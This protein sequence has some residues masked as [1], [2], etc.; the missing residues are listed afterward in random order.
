[1]PFHLNK[2]MCSGTLTRDPEIKH[3]P[4]G[5]AVG[6]LGLA[7]NRVYKVGDE[8]REETLFLD[9]EVWGRTAEVI[10]EHCAKGHTIYLEGHLKLD[11]WDDKQTGQK[12]SKIKMVVEEFKFVSTPKDSASN[13]G[14]SQPPARQ[15]QQ[16]RPAQRPPADDD[17]EESDIPF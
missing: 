16:S 13:T 4:K 11:S 12:R 6:Q 1:M 5:T 17:I 3:T 2:M 10:G 8:K 14:G 9:V 7:V 15:Q